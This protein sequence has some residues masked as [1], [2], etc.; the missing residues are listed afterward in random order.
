MTQVEESTSPNMDID[1]KETAQLE[2]FVKLLVELKIVDSTEPLSSNNVLS[3]VSLHSSNHASIQTKPVIN[4]ELSETEVEANINTVDRNSQFLENDIPT[5][6]LEAAID[7]KSHFISD[8]Q[9]LDN[10][11]LSKISVLDE[12]DKSNIF[13]LPSHNELES[14]NNQT[15]NSDLKYNQYDSHGKYSKITNKEESNIAFKKLQKL[16]FGPEI[17]DLNT[18]YENIQNSI[19]KLENKI[20]NND[21]LINLLLPLFS[22][23]IRRKI[24]ISKED[25]IQAI[26]PIIDDLIRTR[27]KEHPVN[28]GEALSTVIPSALENVSLEDLANALAPT[29]GEAIKKQIEIEQDKIVDALYPVIGNTISKYMI[30]TVKSIN[31]KIEENLSFRG[32]N[33]KIKAKLQG[34]SE[35][36]LIVKE[37]LGF[38]IQAIFLIHKGSGLLISEIQPLQEERL[39]S[40]MVAGMLT[41]IR[42][43]ANE[44]ITK[45]GKISELGE[46]D[47]GASKIILE[48]AGYCYLAIIVNGEPSKSLIKEMRATLCFIIKKYGKSIE[49]FDGNLEI[50]PSEI[51]AS[52]EKLGNYKNNE[53]NKSKKS[54]LSPLLILSLTI[55]SAIGIPWGIWEYRSAVISFTEDKIR[56]ALDS[57][58]ELS[59]YNLHVKENQGKLK[60]T[61][62]LPNKWLRKKAEQI[63]KA[64][65]PN[66]SIENKIIPVDIPIDPILAKAEV[67]RVTK[68]L[69][70]MSGTVVSTN[71]IDDKVIIKGSVRQIADNKK[72]IAAFEQ[73]PGVKFVSSAVEVKPLKVGVRIYFSSDSATLPRNIDDILKEVQ[74]FLNKY[75]TTKLKIIG[76]SNSLA[77]QN[78]QTIALKRAL[79]VK[80]MLLQRGIDPSRLQEKIRI[81]LPPGVTKE[82][83]SWMR[84]CVIFEP[85]TE[86]NS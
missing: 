3:T 40:D 45:N 31:E 85:V 44:C 82:Q 75:P 12:I 61:G 46:I 63:T 42:E 66:W 55:L 70:Q 34:V 62:K 65:V 8:S 52:L 9:P 56:V 50:I 22:E 13:E 2:D 26:A 53:S 27:G 6:Y 73:I 43:F 77:N 37:S 48:V 80:K 59:I 54:K 49:K 33:R 71:F 57:T 7:L 15:P 4:L 16:L 78:S 24:S 14:I 79:N 17:S 74:S 23:V 1:S 41:A 20:Y 5:D 72:I 67:E 32:I 51:N 81:D 38:S 86:N 28:M 84:R 83:P 29:I 58:P 21:E 36:E 11:I 10:N 76:Y 25:I 68:I 47:Y 64:A 19:L 39:E 18:R 60:L 35:A 30:E 69:N